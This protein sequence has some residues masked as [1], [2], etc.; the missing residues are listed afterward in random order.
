MTP[1]LVCSQATNGNTC[2]SL[3]IRCGLILFAQIVYDGGGVMPST[4]INT[5][6]PPRPFNISVPSH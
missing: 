5:S 4:S 6:S 2:W 1:Y 3:S